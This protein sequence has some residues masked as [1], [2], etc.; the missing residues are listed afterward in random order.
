MP[1]VPHQPSLSWSFDLLK[2]P[3]LVQ[4]PLPLGWTTGLCEPELPLEEGP[5]PAPVPRTGESGIGA[6]TSKLLLALHW[7]P[8]HIPPFPGPLKLAWGR[9][10]LEG[11]VF[12]PASDSVLFSQLVPGISLGAESSLSLPHSLSLPAVKFEKNPLC[13]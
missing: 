1:S 3:F 11:R 8:S 12:T 13:L 10:C 7:G 2:P 6:L 5:G 9:G 4:E